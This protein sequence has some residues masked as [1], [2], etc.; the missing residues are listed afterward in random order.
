MEHSGKELKP[1]KRGKLEEYFFLFGYAHKL[2]ELEHTVFHKHSKI[3]GANIG[4]FFAD[5]N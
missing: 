4:I 1:K 5:Y 2:S 3:P